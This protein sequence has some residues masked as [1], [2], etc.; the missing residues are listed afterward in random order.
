MAST[1][2][3]KELLAFIDGW[4]EHR[5]KLAK[6]ERQSGLHLQDVDEALAEAI[7][8]EKGEIARLDA[9]IASAAKKVAQ[10]PLSLLDDRL[11]ALCR[12]NLQYARQSFKDDDEN[13]CGDCAQARDW[14]ELR[15]SCFPGDGVIFY[16]FLAEELNRGGCSDEAEKLTKKV[17]SRLP[18]DDRQV[19]AAGYL[20]AA[21]LCA[22]DGEMLKLFEARHAYAEALRQLS[23]LLSHS[24]EAG[25]RKEAKSFDVLK[26][27]VEKRLSDIGGRLASAAESSSE[28]PPPTQPWGAPTEKLP[29][30]PP[31]TSSKVVPFRPRRIPVVGEIAAGKEII[32][33]DD[34][35]GYIQQ[36]GRLEF[37]FRGQPL[38]P[39]PLGKSRITFSQEYDYFA[40]QVSG[41]SMNRADISPG[42]YVVVRRTKA[43]AQGD[44]VAVV[45]RD[46][47]DNRATL[48][49]ILIESN[50]VTLKPESSNPK[51]ESRFLP[52]EAF[53]SD[54]PSVTIVGI[55]IAVLK[56][57]PLK[58]P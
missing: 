51:H 42:D 12:E 16:L 44:I 4:L 58:T 17:L 26:T 30:P 28:G 55:A 2:S 9:D 24:H 33:P 10:D 47:D 34:I 57:H 13:H 40:A 1:N 29:E 41:D 31:E 50:K 23:I 14:L 5:D 35:V 25:Y 22:Q 38:E 27:S 21:N 53:A 8:E 56:P 54:N 49:R 19:R 46:E 52:P 18:S 48:K 6:L 43:P 32:N 37:E 11:S 36:T 39:R 20:V 3:Y 7:E 15:K 45:F